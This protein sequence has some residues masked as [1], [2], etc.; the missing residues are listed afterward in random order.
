MTLINPENRLPTPAEL[1]QSGDLA[2]RAAL[3]ALERRYLD[4]LSWDRVRFRQVRQPLDWQMDAR[5]IQLDRVGQSGENAQQ[6]LRLGMNNLLSVM[7]SSLGSGSLI[8]ALGSDGRTHAL[9][10]GVRAASAASATQAATA[11]SASSQLGALTGALRGSLPGSQWTPLTPS[12]AQR[13]LLTPLSEWGSLG[14][15]T[16]IPSFKL[17]SQE[18]QGLE[19]LVEALAGHAYQLLVIADPLPQASI[20]TMLERARALSGEL[21][22]H[23]KHALNVSRANST[24]FN[25]SV[26]EESNESQSATT[27][28]SRGINQQSIG[29]SAGSGLSMAIALLGMAAGLGPAAVLL[30]ELASSGASA[31]SGRKSS[32][33][34]DSTSDTQVSGRGRSDS[35]STGSSDSDTH[36]VDA[37]L[38]NKNAEYAEAMLDRIIERLQKGRGVGLWN[39]GVYLIAPDAATLA[40]GQSYLR[41]FSAG[42]E[43]DSE[44][45]RTIDLTRMLS[46]GASGATALDI[47]RAALSALTNPALEFADPNAHHPLGSAFESLATPL[48]TDELSLWMNLPTREMSGVSVQSV[49]HFGLNPPLLHSS[50]A[51]LMLG[52]VL[53]ASGGTGRAVTL[54]ADRL[55]RH[56]FITGTTGS[57]KTNTTLQLIRQLHARG[58]P[59]LVIEPAKTEYR[60]LLADPD[61]AGSLQIFTLG[62]EQASP[63]RL[64]PFEFVPGFGLLTHI[65]LLKATF[66]AAFPMYASMPYLLEEAILDVYTLRGWDLA[67][68]RNQFWDQSMGDANAYLPTL[69]DLFSQ[70]DAV[71]DRKQYAQQL[72]MDLTAALKARISS[73]RVGS[74]GLMLDV[75][76]SI[77]IGELLARPTILELQD[78]GDDAEKAFV[79]GL[80]LTLL[81]EYRQV[82]PS[83]GESLQHLT[84]IEEAHR[85]LK[86]VGTADNPEIANPQARAVETFGNILAEVR[87]YGEGIIV[88][89]QIASKL[90]PDIIKNTNLKIIH[91]VMARDDRD[92]VGGAI[93]LDEAQRGRLVTL[94]P[95]EAVLHSDDMD[96]ALLVRMEHARS[97]LPRGST[98]PAASVAAHMRSTHE[99]LADYYKES[100]PAAP[101]IERVGCA[102]CRARCRYGSR[103]AQRINTPKMLSLL[104][105]TDALKDPKG[106]VSL[107]ALDAVL[108]QQA[109]LMLRAADATHSADNLHDLKHCILTHYTDDE[110]VL[111]R[112]AE[113]VIE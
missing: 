55:V 13:D 11:Q 61:I 66:N 109:H 19:R 68:G 89:D 25:E 91:R 73:L 29:A 77:P 52:E 42:Q 24:S 40:Q 35:T 37:E 110:S 95:G 97:T 80:L 63:F 78:L 88:I 92:E 30:G 56:A 104:T 90:S 86:R 107:T 69:G 6:M 16:G 98:I 48:N 18:G 39:V 36:T 93:N 82:M 106:N 96:Q 5:F 59:F 4:N 7:H 44:S 72:R 79:M 34:G 53:S 21:H 20:D 9:H 75:Q 111:D 41:A 26:S 2:A 87:E 22:G 10:M 49:V 17:D 8:F 64:N 60:A 57:G 3:F 84:V 32:N 81:Y 100:W 74:K 58:I 67:T 102:T 70:I 108:N 45:I 33:S 50:Q 101:L 31:I 83:A 12:A 62:N 1:R 47:P 23:V 27:G 28:T 94:K 51:G 71:V 43:T 76:R 85:L 99:Y 14:V 46:G 65:D 112:H 38:L 15:M 113:F 105:R 103:V 54:P